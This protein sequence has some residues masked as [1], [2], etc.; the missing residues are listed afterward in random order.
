MYGLVKTSPCPSGRGSQEGWVLWA[1]SYGEAGCRTRQSRCPA[2]RMSCDQIVTHREAAKAT[3]QFCKAFTAR[4][5]IVNAEAKARGKSPE[6]ET[7]H[8]AL[9][10]HG[11]DYVS[12]IVIEV[13]P[14]DLRTGQ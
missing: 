8:I 14:D 12:H 7:D 1:C 6:G 13:G 2:S 4:N 3:S 5:K 9:T 10:K 11:I